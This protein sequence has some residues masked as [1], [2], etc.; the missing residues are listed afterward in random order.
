MGKGTPSHTRGVDLLRGESLISRCWSWS[1]DVSGEGDPPQKLPGVLGCPQ[2]REGWPG[3]GCEG[4]LALVHSHCIP[5]CQAPSLLVTGDNGP[6]CKT[7]AARRVIAEP[8]S[9]GRT[10][11]EIT[12]QCCCRAGASPTPA[13]GSGV[14][15]SPG[16]VGAA[17]AVTVSH[18]HG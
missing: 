9:T 11:M 15:P 17:G 2:G 14:S 18:T 13:R 12:A 6:I 4:L 16:A 5:A 8:P 1:R 7:S 3:K 10:G